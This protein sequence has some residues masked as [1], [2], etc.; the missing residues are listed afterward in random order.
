M[1]NNNEQMIMTLLNFDKYLEASYIAEELH[2]SDKTVR[3][4]IKK[5][6]DEFFEKY[7]FKLIESKP[8]NGFKLSSFY[9]DKNFSVEN[10]FQ[11]STPDSGM[12]KTL[13]ALLFSYPNKHTEKVLNLEYY[14]KGVKEKK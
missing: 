1:H 11:D 13:L 8:G 7:G 2:I 14:S 12:K 9:R 5:L 4:A 3:R 10:D 6:N